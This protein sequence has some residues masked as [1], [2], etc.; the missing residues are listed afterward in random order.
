MWEVSEGLADAFSDVEQFIG[1]CR[2]SNCIHQAEPGC[3]IK[4]AIERG[5]L[6]ISRW[7]SYRKLKREAATQEEMLR[8]KREWS[9]GAAK[10]NK[11]R[12]KEIW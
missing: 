8:R 1:K 10:A 9:K 11:Q 2:F 6:D 5:E 7:E 12:R 3:A 4:A